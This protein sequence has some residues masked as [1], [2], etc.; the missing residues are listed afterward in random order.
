VEPEVEQAAFDLLAACGYDVRVLPVVGAGASLLSK[1]F[2][3]AAV[4]HAGKVLEAL[5]QVDPKREAAVVGIEPPD[6]YCLK[7]DYFDLLPERKQEIAERV[8]KVWLLDEFWSVR[9]RFN[10]CA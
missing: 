9:R 4:R 7:N 1:G 3:E 5:D 8:K 10:V 6:I 2:V